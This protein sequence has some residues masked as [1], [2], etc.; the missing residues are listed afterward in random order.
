MLTRRELFARGVAAGAVAGAGALTAGCGGGGS[1]VVTGSVSVGGQPLRDGLITFVSQTGKRDAHA[2]AIIEGK[3]TTGPIP[4]G[5]TKVTVI[6]GMGRPAVET[7]AGDNRP[8][9]KERG[10]KQ[11]TVPERYGN[12][13]TSGLEYTVVKGDQTKDFDLTP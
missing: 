2:A 7:G 9:A 13:D 6:V 3:F 12:P 5:D 11:V 1:G 10:P 8:A 4:S